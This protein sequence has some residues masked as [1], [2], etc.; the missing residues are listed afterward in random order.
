MKKINNYD[1][2]ILLIPI[3][4]LF[5][6]FYF[7]LETLTHIFDS[8]HHGSILLNALDILNGRIPYKEIFIQYGLLNPIINSVFLR[9]FNYDIIGIYIA[10]TSFYCLGIFFLSLKSKKLS[11]YT[12]CLLTTLLILFNHPIPE[13]PWPNYTAFFFLTLS[14]YIFDE[15]NLNKIFLSSFLLCLA[16]L[17]RENFYYFIIPSIIFINS[18]L[19]LKY[20]NLKINIYSL[21][22]FIFPLIIFFIYLYV[23]EIFY[24]W[25]EFQKLPFEY[26]QR[27]DKSLFILLKEFFNFFIIKIPFLIG[28][29]PQ[30]FLILL[31]LL[32]NI[33]VLIDEL[34]FKKNNNINIIYISVLSLTSLIVSINLEIFRMYTSIVIGLPI[35][36]YKINSFE[37]NENKFIIIFLITFISAFSIYTS[38]KGNVKFFKNI[39]YDQSFNFKDHKFFKN[40]KWEDDKWKFVNQFVEIDNQIKQKCKLNYVLNLTPS[41]FIL[42]L[43]ELDRIQMSP[44]FNEH[45]GKE[46]HIM[47]QKNFKKTANKKIVNKD[48]YILSMENNIEILDN[49]LENYLI[50]HKLNI[51]GLKGSEMRVYVPIECYN[52]LKL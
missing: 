24:K 35:I 18:L 10:T 52:K 21:M 7:S 31:I 42:V 29:S 4:F 1:Y 34:I 26:L 25:V 30:Y 19:F 5:I 39:N 47:F 40:Q 50:S 32:F 48:I 36:F 16:C 23:N 38:P 2:L 14:I 11:N 46:F 8:G 37:K 41:A 20:K 33:Y 3:F 45:V 15:K 27:Y 22:G 9:I 49:S 43:T 13:Y 12:G 17:S 28:T 6:S 44:L 51:S